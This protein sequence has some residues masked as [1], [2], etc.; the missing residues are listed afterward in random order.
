LLAA[1]SA[2]PTRG[3]EQWRDDHTWDPSRQ[4][5][6]V[7]QTDLAPADWLEQ[8]LIDHWS[9]SLSMLPGG[10]DAYARIL[11]PYEGETEA[12]RVG[13]VATALTDPD[14]MVLAGP[15]AWPIG[16]PGARSCP[17]IN[18]RR[19]CRSWPGILPR[20]SAGSCCGPGT[21]GSANGHSARHR[22]RSTRH[23]TCTSCAARITPTLTSLSLP[24][25]IT[26][27]LTTRPGA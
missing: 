6:L 5:E 16:P 9:A 24:G 10:F 17:T 7:V 4:T 19:C 13:R 3:Y 8:A 26:G 2:M 1:G 12:D 18:S 11:C 23:A 15:V 21:A 22:K 20:R 25:R 14:A 27:G